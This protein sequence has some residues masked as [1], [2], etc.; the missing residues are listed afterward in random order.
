MDYKEVNFELN[1]VSSDTREILGAILGEIEFESFIDTKVGMKAYIQ[2]DLFNEQAMKDSLDQ[3]SAAFESLNYS[4]ETIKDQNWNAAWEENFEPIFIDELCCICAPFHKIDRTYEYDICIEPKMSFGTGHHATT[5]LVIKLMLQMNFEQQ[6]VLDMGCGTGVLGILASLKKADKVLGVDVDTWAYENSVENI[7][8]N[9]INNMDVLLGDAMAIPDMVF[10]T[11]IANINRNIL[12]G[13]IPI[14]SAHLKKE[15]ILI[16]S[17]F[18]LRDISMIK[19]KAVENGM[20]FVSYLEH[21][22]WVAV[23]FIKL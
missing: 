23:K 6:Q 12:L 8:R 2:I 7:E 19:E 21:D 17:G 11:V 3:I 4:I 13:D 16:L 14:Y 22:D 18:Y 1:P 15:G 10:D 5:A 9:N 20:E